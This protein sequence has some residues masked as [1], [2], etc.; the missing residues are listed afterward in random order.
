MTIGEPIDIAPYLELSR[1]D[2]KAA[3]RELTL[4]ILREIAALAGAKDYQPRLAGRLWAPAD[5]EASA[6]D[7]ASDDSRAGDDIEGD[8]SEGDVDDTS[9]SGNSPA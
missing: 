7:R 3:Q 1:D 6:D 2:G 4:R 8:E 5:D 9:K